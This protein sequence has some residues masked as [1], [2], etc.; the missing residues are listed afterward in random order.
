MRRIVAAFVLF[1]AWT[2]IPPADTHG[3]EKRSVVDDAGRKVEIPAVPR[4]IVVLNSS[5]LEILYAVGGKAVGRPESTGMPKELYG[6]VRDLPSIGET[7]S[8]NV[9]K[10]ASLSPDLVVGVNMPFHHTLLPALSRAGIPAL[11][12]SINSYEDIIEKIRFFGNLTGN[13]GQAARIIADIEQKTDGIKRAAALQKR[14]KVAIIWG[15]PQS[16]TMAL[17]SSFPGNLVGMLGGINIASGVKPVASMPHYAPLSL[18][19]VLSKDPDMIFLITH[20]HDGKVSEKFRKEME[21]HPAWKGLRAI[22][23]GRLYPL[24]YSLFGV[25]P[26]VRVT[27]AVEHIAALLYPEIAET[28]RK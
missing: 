11:L 23:E 28:G 25:N 17:P 14:K 16:F 10:I 4:R 6:K 21:S 2:G 7:P 15:S 27:K 22:R 1:L 18:E 26:A 19:Y 24:P 13:T 5:N 20:G 9:E 8:P 3:S 12:L